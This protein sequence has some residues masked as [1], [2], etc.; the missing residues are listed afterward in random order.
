MPVE[1]GR[2]P[3]ELNALLKKLAA[4]FRFALLAGAAT[5]R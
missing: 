1:R 2:E 4:P 5:V 3:G